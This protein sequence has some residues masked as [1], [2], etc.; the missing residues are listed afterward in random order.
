MNK[1][2]N[3]KNTG[4]GEIITFDNIPPFEI[5]PTTPEEIAVA[6]VGTIR[7]TI[8]WINEVWVL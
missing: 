2:S 4:T 5:P 3:N 8:L 7:E 6:S 1:D